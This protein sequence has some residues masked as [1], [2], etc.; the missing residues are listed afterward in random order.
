[1]FSFSKS[2]LTR[3]GVA[4]ATVGL[5]LLLTFQIDSIASRTPFALF[6]AAVMIATWYGGRKPGLLV[7]ALSVVLTK[8]FLIAPLRSLWLTD[9]S[10]FQLATFVLVAAVI[11]W[12]TAARQNS[13]NLLREREAHYRLLFE[14]N[15][16]PL[17]VYDV[18]TLAFMAVNEAA[19]R[20]YQFSREEFLAMTIKDI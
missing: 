5:A 1:M 6:F 12:L 18:E 9:Q 4:I 16:L 17:W 3:W 14:N 13:E 15:P 11:N 19:V 2:V 20:A 8:Y 7:I 10:F